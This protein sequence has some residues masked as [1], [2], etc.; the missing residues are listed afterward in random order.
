MQPSSSSSLSTEALVLIATQR[1]SPHPPKDSGSSSSVSTETLML[2]ARQPNLPPNKSHSNTTNF[3]RRKSQDSDQ[4]SLTPSDVTLSD[5]DQQ[6]EQAAK[7]L[8]QFSQLLSNG[9]SSH[10]SRSEEDL[11]G[12]YQ[13]ETVD[14][15]ARLEGSPNLPI[16]EDQPV[17]PSQLGK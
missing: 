15:D 16:N 8:Q 17:L 13:V 2:I 9:E 5:D 12:D 6:V 10:S 7:H 1:T 14:A 4:Y 3:M 11:D